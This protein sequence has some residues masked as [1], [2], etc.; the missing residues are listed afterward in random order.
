VSPDNTSECPLKSNRK[1]KVWPSNVAWRDGDALGRHADGPAVGR[2]PC[3]RL[4]EV[5]HHRR[6]A[7]RTLHGERRAPAVEPA[8]EPEIRPAHRVIEVE[9]ADQHMLDAAEDLER[10][11]LQ[12]ALAQPRSGIDEDALVPRFDERDR[13]VPIERRA[14]RPGAEQRDPQIRGCARRCGHIPSFSLLTSLFSPQVA[15]FF[16]NLLNVNQKV[17]GLS[18]N[19]AASSGWS[20]WPTT[21]LAT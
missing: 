2:V 15:G 12:Q 11:G 3:K 19:V 4:L 18:A 10:A 6:G 7:N 21:L 1:P 8:G 17:P 5:P 16:S 9:M 14:R 13:T 20:S